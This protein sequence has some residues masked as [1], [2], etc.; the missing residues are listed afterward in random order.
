MEQEQIEQQ[1]TE[2]ES[3]STTDRVFNLMLGRIQQGEWPVGSQIPGERVLIEEFGVSRIALREALSRL[4]ALGIL[5]ISHGK[6]STVTKMDVEVFGQLFP[7]LLSFEAQQNFENVFQVRL[8]LESH[9]A[10][11]AA[12]HRTEEDVTR[13]EELVEELRELSEKPL[14]EAVGTDLAFHVQVARATQNALFPLLLET[15]SGF[16]TYA[17]VVSCKDN[18][19][20]R[21]R[22]INSHTSIAEAIK[23][24]DADR[25][26]VEMESHLRYSARL[27][28]QEN[29]VS[30]DGSVSDQQEGVPVAV[31]S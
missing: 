21:A 18:P 30:H 31:Q 12:Q 28:A 24:R 13:L 3:I 16:V 22:T 6:S 5:N 4:R 19:A 23:E 29:D 1:E 9:T 2:Q 17:Q 8:A 25:A 20:R 26:R 15:L 27:V 7:L 14:E 10:S 11:L